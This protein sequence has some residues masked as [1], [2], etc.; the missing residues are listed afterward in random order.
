LKHCR[1]DITR[2]SEASE[3]LLLQGYEQGLS[4]DIHAHPALQKPSVKGFSL[5]EL[6][7]ILAIGGILLSIGTIAFND[8]TKKYNIEKQTKELFSVINDARLR[9]IHSKKRHGIVLNP[10][11]YV[12][13]NYS[14]ENENRLAGQAILTRTVQYTLTKNSGGGT[15]AGDLFVFDT[16]G[17]IDNGVGI[18]ILVNPAN[19]GAAQDCIV[20]SEGRTNMG[21]LSNGVCGY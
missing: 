13:R 6:V 17:F 10:S 12:M 9:S 4:G 3:F 7:I 18:T 14:S 19:S 21:K 16:R 15:L 11:Q 20:L 8:W 5:V 1:I 2:A